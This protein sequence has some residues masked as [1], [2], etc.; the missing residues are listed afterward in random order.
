MDV[1]RAIDLAA[2]ISNVPDAACREADDP[3]TPISIRRIDRRD[4]DRARVIHRASPKTD[5]Q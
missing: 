2:P 5:R 4:R 1:V 3:G